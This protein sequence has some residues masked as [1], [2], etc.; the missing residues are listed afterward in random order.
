[1]SHAFSSFRLSP[2]SSVIPA[3]RRT[4]LLFFLAGFLHI[5]AFA[6]YPEDWPGCSMAEL[7]AENP[8][9]AVQD[10][11]AG[12]SIRQKENIQSYDGFWAYEF[13]AG[14]M[15][16]AHWNSENI[17]EKGLKARHFNGARDRTEA[18]IEL[19]KER[20]GE[21]QRYRR[22]GVTFRKLKAP[23]DYDVIA[24]IWEM[25]EINCKVALRYS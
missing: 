15:E 20:L 6:Q 22:K 7:L 14:T 13:S 11:E 1:M 18:L 3:L 21:P 24:G 5:S 4:T 10:D 16:F 17:A 25:E 8:A 2:P 9:L 12:N 23:R 19:Y